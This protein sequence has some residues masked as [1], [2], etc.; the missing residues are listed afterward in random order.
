V[1][2]YNGDCSRHGSPQEPHIGETDVS[3]Q[4][5]TPGQGP[6]CMCTGSE[7][8][9]IAYIRRNQQ[10]S[11]NTERDGKCTFMYICMYCVGCVEAG[12]RGNV[13]HRVYV[14]V[15][16][17]AVGVSSFLPLRGLQVSTSGHQV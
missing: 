13:H 12:F 4:S 16:G 9:D 7:C 3:P 8:I 5:R 1:P 11:R 17:Q 6:A 2:S 15:R 10:S 14:E